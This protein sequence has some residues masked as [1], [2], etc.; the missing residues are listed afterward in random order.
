M[1][2]YEKLFKLK[3]A[4]NGY[5]ES[6]KRNENKIQK[7]I[8]KLGFFVIVTSKEMPASETLDTFRGG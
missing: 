1:V 8:D 4:G 6:Y 5:L 7:E 3:Y 2:S